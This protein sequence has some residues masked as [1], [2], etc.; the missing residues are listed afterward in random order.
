MSNEITIKTEN[1]IVSLSALN[2]DNIKNTALISEVVNLDPLAKTLLAGEVEKVKTQSAVAQVLDRVFRSGLYKADFK[3]IGDFAESIG[4]TAS[5]ALFSKSQISQLCTSGRIY[6]DPKAPESLKH[7]AP[8]S[9]P[10]AQGCI[11]DDAKRAEL[12]KRAKDHKG[13]FTQDEMR[14]MNKEISA[15]MDKPKTGKAVSLFYGK[16]NGKSV[17]GPVEN[18]AKRDDWEVWGSANYD[19]FMPVKA[20]NDKSPRYVCIKG[21]SASLLTLS[22]KG[23]TPGKGKGKTP[24]K[25]KAQSK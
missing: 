1:S 4:L 6:N 7:T 12:Y 8:F 20:G 21:M 9:L 5:K 3:T 25:G 14:K 2:V 18:P 10:G 15:Q 11:N 19:E 13:G 23:K 22:T 17:S 16:L 24:G